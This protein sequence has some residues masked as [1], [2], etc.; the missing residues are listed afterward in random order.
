MKE[1]ERQLQEEVAK[2]S[3]KVKIQQSEIER[4]SEEF[5]K[6]YIRSLS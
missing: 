2:L 5:N 4:L 3:N 1:R 6:R